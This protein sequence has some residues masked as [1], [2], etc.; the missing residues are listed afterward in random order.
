[1]KSVPKNWIDVRENGVLDKILGPQKGH[2]EAGVRGK[3][4][5][6]FVLFF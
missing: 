1:V 2:A 6:S 4:G 3:H 5:A